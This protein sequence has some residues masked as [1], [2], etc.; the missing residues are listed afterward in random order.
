MPWVATRWRRSSVARRQR[1]GGRISGEMR[2]QASTT[3]NSKPPR[4]SIGRRSGR[5]S[6]GD[7][8][9][10][11]GGSVDIG[12]R[13]RKSS[14]LAEV[15]LPDLLVGGEVGGGVGE[16]DLA[17]LQDVSAVSHVE[18]HERVL[19]HQEDGRP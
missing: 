3:A 6:P 19:L 14:D 7:R 18:R 12:V 9:G 2:I 17:G 5:Y 4:I 10:G 16:D 15:G 8:R 11:R 1:A 13:R